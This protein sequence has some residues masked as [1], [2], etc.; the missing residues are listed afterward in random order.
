MQIENLTQEQLDQL[1]K[2]ME[3]LKQENAKLN[4]DKSDLLKDLTVI[5]ISCFSLLQAFGILDANGD[6]QQPK[7]LQ[8]MK[9]I[10]KMV[11]EGFDGKEDTLLHRIYKPMIPFATKYKHL[12]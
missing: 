2:E 1:L 6:P 12:K 11:M 4:F 3:T 5:K 10:T 7:K 9:S 8:M